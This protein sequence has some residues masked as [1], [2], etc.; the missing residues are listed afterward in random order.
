MAERE[1]ER[2]SPLSPWAS[3]VVLITKNYMFIHFCVDHKILYAITLKIWNT[4]LQIND[5]IDQLQRVTI[6]VS[7]DLTIGFWQV[8]LEEGNQEKMTIVCWEALS[9]YTLMPFALCTTINTFQ[10]LMN[11]DMGSLR[12]QCASVYIDNINICFKSYDDHLRDLPVMFERLFKAKLKLKPK[13][14]SKRGVSK[15]HCPCFDV[16]L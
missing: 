14:C 4:F 10:S 9:K 5:T 3:P 1:R 11:I 8:P 2:E 7:L 16:T 12:W 15:L 6:F 13:K